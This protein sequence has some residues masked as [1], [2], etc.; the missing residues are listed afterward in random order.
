MPLVCQKRSGAFFQRFQGECIDALVKSIRPLDDD[1]QFH[2]FQHAD[3]VGRK[4]ALMPTVAQH[5][6]ELA[7]RRFATALY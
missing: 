3:D 6:V 1:R 5:F 2:R 4:D 7:S